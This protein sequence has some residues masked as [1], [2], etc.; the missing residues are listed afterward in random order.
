MLFAAP[1]TAHFSTG[2]NVRVIHIAETAN[3]LTAYYRL[4]FALAVANGLGPQQPDGTFAAAPYTYNERIGT[5]PVHFVN[6]AA[7][8]DDPLGLG[9][10]VAGSHAL[11]VEGQPIAGQAV[12]ARVLARGNTPPFNTLAEARAAFDGPV[13]PQLDGE[14]EVN[15]ALVDVRVDYPF[16]GDIGTLTVSSTLAPGEMAAHDTQNL[17]VLH[18]MDGTTRSQ[19]VGGLLAEPV[20]VYEPVWRAMAQFMALGVEHIVFGLDHVFF[21]LCLVI[22]AATLGGLAWRVTGFTLG[23]TVTLLA[24]YYGYVPEG[25]WF[26][27]AVEVGIAASI[28]YAAAV[29]MAGWR[30]PLVAFG[31]T[32]AL[33]LL[34]GFGFSSSLRELVRPD[35]PDTVARLASFNIGVEVGQLAIVAL[36]WPALVWLARSSPARRARAVDVVAI[37]AIWVAGL[38]VLERVP[39]LWV[40]V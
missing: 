30:N 18:A 2:F 3:G 17:I 19:Q 1:A 20:T 13:Y 40:E 37:G 39:L 36:A 27:P 25:A 31:V 33:G 9:E 28:I 22:G 35:E 32:S 24:G 4:S 14:L 11:M 26:V 29:P 34:H 6:P 21:V 8:M 38:W 10:I 12:E 16:S 23:H 15:S 5:E 7:V